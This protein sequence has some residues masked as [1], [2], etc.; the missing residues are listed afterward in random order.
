[1][2]GPSGSVLGGTGRGRDHGNLGLQPGAPGT[3]LPPARA[4]LHVCVWGIGTG[5]ASFVSVASGSSCAGPGSD[6]HPATCRCP[7][8]ITMERAWSC[9]SRPTLSCI[10][11]LER[12]PL[13]WPWAASVGPTQGA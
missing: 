10:T 2:G 4:S 1:M 6:P 3:Q 13:S 11:C 5:K 9:V 7:R 12:H 8:E